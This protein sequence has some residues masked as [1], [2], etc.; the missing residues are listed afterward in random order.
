MLSV[1]VTMFRLSRITQKS[2]ATQRQLWRDVNAWT[3]MCRAASNSTNISGQST[4]VSAPD[5]RSSGSVKQG[6]LP[7]GLTKL[8]PTRCCGC[9]VELQLEDK[10]KQGCVLV[11]KKLCHQ[12]LNSL[13]SSAKNS[14]ALSLKPTACGGHQGWSAKIIFGS[15]TNI[16]FR[17]DQHVVYPLFGFIYWRHLAWL[18]PETVFEPLLELSVLRCM[19]CILKIILIASKWHIT[20]GAV[21]IW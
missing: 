10:N 11:C 9:G 21:S 17:R 20:T 15:T 1:T 19:A 8:L 2:P 16:I 13:E 18:A 14:S 7:T 6:A 3:T 4:P 12:N 5:G